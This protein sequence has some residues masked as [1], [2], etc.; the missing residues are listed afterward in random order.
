MLLPTFPNGQKN[1]S[2][3]VD[4]PQKP[5]KKQNFVISLEIHETLKLTYMLYIYPKQTLP[6]SFRL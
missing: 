4:V 2:L 1:T 6:G 5:Q 3:Q